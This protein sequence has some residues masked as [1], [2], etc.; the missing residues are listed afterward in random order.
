MPGFF[1]S[2]AITFLL[3]LFVFLPHS[4]AL[5]HLRFPTMKTNGFL[6]SLLVAGGAQAQLTATEHY[7]RICP[8]LNR[9][10]E[11]I[12]PGY[13][14]RYSCGSFGNH[15]GVRVHASNPMDC[16]MLCQ[17]TDGCE[18]SSWLADQRKCVLSG[19]NGSGIRQNTVYMKRVEYQE[20]MDN[21]DPF[22]DAEPMQEPLCTTELGYC[23]DQALKGQQ[24]SAAQLKACEDQRLQQQADSTVEINKCE[25]AR[26]ASQQQSAML[27]S[28]CESNNAANQQVAAAQLSQCQSDNLQDQQ[29]CIA[30]VTQCKAE[31]AEQHQDHVLQIEKLKAAHAQALKLSNDKV[32]KLQSDINFDNSV[33]CKKKSP[34]LFRGCLRVC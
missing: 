16:A 8:G 7:D 33:R 28:E 27:L 25:S 22:L 20:F 4:K 3:F 17:N 11:E 30:Q 26:R 19:S 12:N 10:T 29:K 6:Q 5:V 24:L 31:Q 13:V 23:R 21:G 14:V 2:A 15:N 1:P 32:A 18:G 9:M 34:N